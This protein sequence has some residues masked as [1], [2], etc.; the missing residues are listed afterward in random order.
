MDKVSWSVTGQV[1]GQIVTTDSGQVVE[2]VAVYF[3]TG[4]GNSGSVFVPQAHY[5]NTAKVK[6]LIRAE[7]RQIDAIGSLAENFPTGG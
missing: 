6:E 1:T 7:A 2:G 3:V 4:D 5:H